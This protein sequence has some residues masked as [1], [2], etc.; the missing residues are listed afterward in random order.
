MYT[1]PKRQLALVDLSDE[2]VVEIGPCRTAIKIRIFVRDPVSVWVGSGGGRGGSVFVCVLSHL[3]TEAAAV[4]IDASCRS[5][6]II[7]V[8]VLCGLALDLGVCILLS[9]ILGKQALHIVGGRPKGSA[10]K[11]SNMSAVSWQ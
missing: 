9:S 2:G 11:A 4:R 8:D 6:H 3:E 5:S 7:I 1:G 10:C